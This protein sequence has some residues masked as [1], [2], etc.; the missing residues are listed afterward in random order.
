MGDEHYPPDNFERRGG[1]RPASQ[2]DVLRPQFKQAGRSIAPRDR[3]RAT[4]Y[5]DPKYDVVEGDGMY[6]RGQ[7][8][9]S[10]GMY[11]S[12]LPQ[13][14]VHTRQ[15]IE[16]FGNLILIVSGKLHRARR[17]CHLHLARPLSLATQRLFNHSRPT[18][19][20]IKTCTTMKK[21]IGT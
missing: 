16:Y 2:Y 4:Q 19:F 21:V 8:L 9:D 13:C 5:D 3:Y 14:F 20:V 6:D 18:V 7:Q 10:F 17:D 15:M 12:H 11:F 1:L